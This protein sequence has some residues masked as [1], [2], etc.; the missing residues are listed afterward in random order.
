MS[1]SD[2]PAQGIPFMGEKMRCVMC[3]K[4]QRSDPNVSS[5]WRMILLD[6]KRFYACPDEFP[7]DETATADEFSVAYQKVMLRCIAL[8]NARR[9][10]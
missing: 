1:D 9:Y 8:L 10:H 5:Q 6:G 3:D 7:P 4:V 2:Q